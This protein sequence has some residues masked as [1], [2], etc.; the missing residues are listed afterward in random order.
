ME[1]KYGREPH[2]TQHMMGSQGEMK[3]YKTQKHKNILGASQREKSGFLEKVQSNTHVFP[4]TDNPSPCE[5]NYPKTR[6]RKI[7]TRGF[8]LLFIEDY[9]LF[10]IE[11]LQCPVEEGVEVVEQ[12]SL[13]VEEEHELT[14]FL[15]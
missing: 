12:S 7:N 13:G 1:E 4:K 2:H 6:F 11:I 8:W 3:K 15:R 14:C 9:T 10:K 5:T